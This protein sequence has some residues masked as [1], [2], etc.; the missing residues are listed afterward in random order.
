[1][2]IS[3]LEY[4][5]SLGR[6]ERVVRQ[7]TD[8]VRRL[9]LFHPIGEIRKSLTF[10]V[11]LWR[12]ADS[13]HVAAPARFQIFA[14][15]IHFGRVRSDELSG[16]GLQIVEILRR[17]IIH[18]SFCRLQIGSLKAVV[19]ASR[20][21]GKLIID[22]LGDAVHKNRHDLRCPAQ[23]IPISGLCGIRC[24]PAGRPCPRKRR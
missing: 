8:R 17:H 15:R 11:S 18:L 24:D 4:G 3:T 1:M 10:T 21:E 16:G 5:N 22:S 12:E 6:G 9:L 23:Q 19:L 13:G 7:P 2:G 14:N 20:H